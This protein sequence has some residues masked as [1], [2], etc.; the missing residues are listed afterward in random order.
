MMV[1]KEYL[2]EKYLHMY[3]HIIHELLLPSTLFTVSIKCTKI[4]SHYIF[5]RNLFEAIKDNIN[6]E[7]K[8]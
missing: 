7:Y 6:Y 5:C 3:D 1:I 8:I 2:V 4:G